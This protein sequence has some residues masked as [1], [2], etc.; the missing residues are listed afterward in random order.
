MLHFIY[1]VSFG[2]FSS[3][4]LYKQLAVNISVSSLFLLRISPGRDVAGVQSTCSFWS[5]VS[6]S[7]SLVFSIATVGTLSDLQIPA[8]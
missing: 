6:Q 3:F 2:V 1:S 8:R 4:Y 5:Q 7:F